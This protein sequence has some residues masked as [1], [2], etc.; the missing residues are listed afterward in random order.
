MD[1]RSLLKN[2]PVRS[3]EAFLGIRDLLLHPGRGG[4]PSP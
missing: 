4:L 3:I 2:S 1:T